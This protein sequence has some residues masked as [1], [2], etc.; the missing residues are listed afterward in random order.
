MA[1][2]EVGDIVELRTGGPDLTVV[3]ADSADSEVKVAWFVGGALAFEWLPVAALQLVEKLGDE[4]D[5]VD[6][7]GQPGER[8]AEDAGPLVRGEDPGTDLD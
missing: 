7:D 6:A 4:A 5:E 8:E 1:G 3:S 2:Y